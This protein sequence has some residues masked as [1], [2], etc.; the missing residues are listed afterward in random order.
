M[1]LQKSDDRID[2][3]GKENRKRKDD[4]DRPHDVDNGKRQPEHQDRQQYPCS[5]AI[6]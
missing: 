2:Q 4:N 6:K 5:S 1:A 3:I